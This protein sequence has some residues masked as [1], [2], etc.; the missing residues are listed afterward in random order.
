MFSMNAK[1]L[2]NPEFDVVVFLDKF[3]PTLVQG[4]SAIEDIKNA[5]IEL[6]SY[7]CDIIILDEITIS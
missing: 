5:I 7:N 3:L 1:I 6:Q 4:D 2:D